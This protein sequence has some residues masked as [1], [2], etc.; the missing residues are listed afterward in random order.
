METLE[1]FYLASKSNGLP[2]LVGPVVRYMRDARDVPNELVADP[3]SMKGYR[4][5]LRRF[6][7]CPL[8]ER[9]QPKTRRYVFLSRPWR[10]KLSQYSFL[11]SYAQ[12]PLLSRKPFSRLAKVMKLPR[13]GQHGE[14]S[15]ALS[16]Q[17]KEAIIESLL[18]HVQDDELALSRGTATVTRNQ[19]SACIFN[20]CQLE[21]DAHVILV[22]HI[23]TCICELSRAPQGTGDPNYEHFLVATQLSKYCAYL[24]S[25]APELLPD[26]PY[27]TENVFDTAVKQAQRDMEG[28]D[29]SQRYELLRTMNQRDRNGED[30]IVVKGALL[31]GTLMV[32]VLNNPARGWRV[33]AEF[34]AELLL[35]LA[36]SNNVAVHGEYLARGGEFITHVWALLTHAGIVSRN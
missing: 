12:V 29:I 11:E 17:V 19:L 20:T 23:A 7:D 28:C 34:W 4:L 35:Y 9:S 22:W 26:H 27:T 8:Y 1:A 10:R 16:A 3:A 31:G 14:F 36:L 25:F 32:Q 13:V 6:A 21:T 24:V 30:N 15:V 5:I 18:P 2:G 33:L